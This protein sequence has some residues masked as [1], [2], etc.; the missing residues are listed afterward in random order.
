MRRRIARICR[1]AGM[2]NE[3]ED[4]I[5]RGEGWDGMGKGKGKSERGVEIAN[6]AGSA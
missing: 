1:A 6:A 3:R 2:P 4:R 5:L